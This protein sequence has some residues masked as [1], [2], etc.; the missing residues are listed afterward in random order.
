MLIII[1]NFPLTK[2]TD[3]DITIIVSVWNTKL[4]M[5]A[6]ITNFVY[7]WKIQPETTVGYILLLVNA[8]KA[9]YP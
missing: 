3:G 6:N 4:Q 7:V 1:S 5:Q 8:G 2:K 9:S